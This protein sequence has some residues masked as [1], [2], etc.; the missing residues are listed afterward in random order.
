MVGRGR[1]DDISA[2]LEEVFEDGEVG[3][4]VDLAYALV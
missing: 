3:L 4:V 1:G 2:I